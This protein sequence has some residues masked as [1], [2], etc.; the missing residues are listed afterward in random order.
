METP[1]IDSSR[2]AEVSRGL[3]RSEVE[4]REKVFSVSDL[5]SRTAGRSPSS[6]SSIDVHKNTVTAFIGPSGCGK[7][8]FIRCFNRMN[9]LIPGAKVTGT[10]LYHGQDLYARTWIRSRSGA[11]SGWSSRSRTR[12]RSR[13]TTTSPSGRA[14]SG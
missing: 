8:T 3:E 2:I 7:S 4:R 5:A 12:S 13:S 11:G 1:Q 9:D 10:V 14:S 6:T